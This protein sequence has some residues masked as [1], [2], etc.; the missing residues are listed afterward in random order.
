LHNKVILVDPLLKP[1]GGGIRISYLVKRE[2][3]V[4]WPSAGEI[5]FG[6]QPALIFA[7]LR[8]DLGLCSY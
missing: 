6:S 2:S 7:S 4:E 8:E 5:I 1:A 3:L